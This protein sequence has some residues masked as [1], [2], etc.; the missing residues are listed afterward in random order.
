MFDSICKFLVETFSDDFATWLLGEPVTLT[1]LSPSELSLEPIRADA[2]ILRESAD[3]IVHLEFQTD[4]KVTI[5]FRMADYRLRGHRRFPAKRMQQTVIYLRPT[6]SELV[7]QTTFRLERTIHEFDVI[8]LW[9]QPT[10]IFL[11]FPG[12]LPLAVLT[13]V[14]NRAE[15]LRQ[16]A[17][18][19][20]QIS[21]LGTQAN[22]AASAY[23]LAGLVLEEDVIHHILRE[24]IVQESVTYRS[25]IRKG[26]EQTMREVALKMLEEAIPLDTIARVTGLSIDQIHQLQTTGAQSTEA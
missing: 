13:Q 8:R 14:Q 4:P 5:P 21:D 24:D 23:V 19:I 11:R 2:L 12:L 10:Q 18:Q 25:I 20:S 17:D 6:N 26:A 15:V 3:L 1:E 9:E 16:V 7:Y 22:L